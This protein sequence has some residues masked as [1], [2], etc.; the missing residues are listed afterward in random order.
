MDSLTRPRSEARESP[1][2]REPGDKREQGTRRPGA[3]LARILFLVS[4]AVVVFAPPA[5]AE[6]WAG[7]CAALIHITPTAEVLYGDDIRTSLGIVSLAAGIEF[8]QTDGPADLT[9]DVG[10]TSGMGALVLGYYDFDR[11]TVMLIPTIP[12]QYPDQDTRQQ[13]NVH[14]RLV[15]HE[16]LHWLGLEHADSPTE[17]MYATIIDD[18][19]RLGLTDRA[20]LRD[21]SLANGCIPQPA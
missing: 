7:G 14:L 15:L 9:Y 18:S 21:Q 13:A 17:V 11:R 12:I 5:L 19:P 6:R 16:T 20:E 8:Q 10:D 3:R 4:L 2:H 1:L